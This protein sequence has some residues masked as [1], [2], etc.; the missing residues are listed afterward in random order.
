MDAL[1]ARGH[2]VDA[3]MRPTADAT[4]LVGSRAEIVRTDYRNVDA[5]AKLLRG[6]DGVI[7]V[8]GGG[9]A[10]SREGLYQMNGDITRR[11]LGACKKGLHG[12]RKFVFVSSLAAFGFRKTSADEV[13]TPVSDYGRSK[14]EAE[15]ETLAAQNDLDVSIVRSPVIYGTRDTRF[16]QMAKWIKRG[17]RPHL[18][19][20]DRVYSL[21]HVEDLARASVDTLEWDRAS[22]TVWHPTD[23]AIHTQRD[24]T[25]AIAGGIEALGDRVTKREMTVGKGLLTFVAHVNQAWS[26]VAGNLPVIHPGKLG[27][28]LENDV[29]CPPCP[30][31][32][33]VQWTPTRN[34]VDGMI[35]TMAWYREHGWL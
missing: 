2:Q 1:I 35:H 17:V 22:A 31:V 30:V 20:P 18:I 32:S 15:L 19:T 23:G 3:W 5:M 4:N 9:L 14:R 33:E 28:L 16:L 29:R 21:M 6:V 13:A 24:I 11:L 26:W 12:P 8:A 7:H 27:D 34:L 25:D 10:P